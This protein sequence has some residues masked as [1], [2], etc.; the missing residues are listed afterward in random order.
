MSGHRQY[1]MAHD[2]PQCGQKDAP[3]TWR[4]AR[5]SSSCWG[6]NYSCCSD[7]CGKA[8]ATNPRRFEMERAE[9]IEQ[10][11]RLEYAIAQCTSRIAELTKGQASG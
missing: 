6:H 2:C 11:S 3:N 10:K 1:W 7:A 4:G 5:M 8:F 9:L